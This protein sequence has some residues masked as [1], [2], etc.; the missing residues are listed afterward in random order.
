LRL[1]TTAIASR[2]AP[3]TIQPASP[4]RFA[5]LRMKITQPLRTFAPTVLGAM[6]LTR[7]SSLPAQDPV[8]DVALPSPPSA[9]PIPA[10]AGD[11][12]NPLESFIT[13]TRPTLSYSYADVGG[14]LSAPGVRNDTSLQT[15]SATFSAELL[16]S[17]LVEYRPMWVT[18]SNDA[19]DDTFSHSAS[20]EA[21][22]LLDA[23]ATRLIHRYHRSAT[24][25]FESGRQTTVES[26]STAANAQR[27][28]GEKT[29]L[30]L[31]VLQNLRFV[32]EFS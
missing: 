13:K 6:L 31:R 28:L 30:D 8:L 29:T 5:R 27:R 12:L 7:F 18:Y 19:F 15:I 26:H 1:S 2:A 11:L 20:L 17:F 23:W 32:K 10:A 16:E 9:V 14:L 3:A 25:L 21:G 4:A 24:P 22:L